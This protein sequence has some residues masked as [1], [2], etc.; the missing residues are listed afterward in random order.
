MHSV[1]VCNFTPTFAV[2]PSKG[3]CRFSHSSGTPLEGAVGMGAESTDIGP[4]ASLW[5]VTNACGK[6]ES[7]IGPEEVQSAQSLS[8]TN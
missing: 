1:S 5:S 7:A 3:A 6:T 4:W 2:V 8:A